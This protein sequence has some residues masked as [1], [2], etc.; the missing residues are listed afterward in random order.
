[1]ETKDKMLPITNVE[2]NKVKCKLMGYLTNYNNKLILLCNKHL[3]TKYCCIVS[4]KYIPL[5]ITQF[6]KLFYFIE[7]E[8]KRDINSNIIEF[9]KISISD[10][11][12]P[13]DKKLLLIDISDSYIVE[14]SFMNLPYDTLSYTI[15][16]HK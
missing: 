11:I 3:N 1:M 14:T 6:L 4:R 10:T 12:I 5:E 16:R 2:D 7:I 9:D 13:N 15:E 8:F